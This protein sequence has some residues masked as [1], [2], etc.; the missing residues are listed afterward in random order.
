MSDIFRL[1]DSK[2]LSRAGGVATLVS[3]I[4]VGLALVALMYAQGAGMARG[5]E[6]ITVVCFG[7]WTVLAVLLI[8]AWVARR[9]P[10]I[11]VTPAARIAIAKGLPGSSRA[12]L[13]ALSRAETTGREFIAE[14]AILMPGNN[15]KTAYDLA[16]GHAAG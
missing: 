14:A 5:G 16:Q 10:G 1:L 11:V 8:L 2:L 9:Q 13:T 7:V 6:W 12:L 3:L 15:Q 4:T